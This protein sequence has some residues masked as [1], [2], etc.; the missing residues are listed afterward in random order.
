MTF[1]TTASLILLA[2]SLS[3]TGTPLTRTIGNAN[4]FS[5]E[6]TVE[7]NDTSQNAYDSLCPRYWFLKYKYD[8]SMRSGYDYRITIRRK[9]IEPGRISISIWGYLKDTL[10]CDSFG[11]VQVTDTVKTDTTVY[12]WNYLRLV[13]KQSAL[14][15]MLQGNE[16]HLKIHL[17]SASINDSIVISRPS[18]EITEVSH[19]FKTAKGKIV[20]AADRNHFNGTMIYDIRGRSVSSSV[21][22]SQLLLMIPKDLNSGNNPRIIILSKR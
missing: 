10:K 19:P 1:N 6:V 7:S 21:G 12:H 5:A 22:S 20:Q 15:Y 9:A 3:V 8:P 2:L 11:I 16:H 13:K 4:S 18:L 17:K 14:P